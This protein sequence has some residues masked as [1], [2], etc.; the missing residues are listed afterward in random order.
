MKIE[1]LWITLRKRPSYM[2]GAVILLGFAVMAIVGPMLYPHGIPSNPNELYAPPSWQHPLG[3][4]YAGR[5][6]LA[7][8]LVGSR[9]VLEVAALAA[10]FTMVVGVVLGL[11]SGYLG[12]V[13]DVVL[14]R[15]T[16]FILTVPSYPLLIIIASVVSISGPV[17]MALLLTLNSWGGMARAIRSQV[18][19]LKQ[20]DYIEAARSLE[21]GPAHIAFREILPMMMPY[22]LMHLIL[23]VTSAV[24]GEVGL[25]FLGI[26]PIQSTNWGVM[27][28][29]AYSEA[30]AIY[31]TSS[32]FYLMAPLAAII[33]L[34]MGAVN[35]TNA[36]DEVFNPQ[37]R[38]G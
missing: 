33:L 18:L 20:Q 37:L 17:P 38:E 31:S 29:F 27:L 9:Y 23:A 22:I 28:N 1:T 11:L 34:Q 10:L 35:F 7:Q 30:G 3:T 24:Y 16:D 4:D 25:F 26:V 14:M 21:L 15:L 12:G 32:V 36:L 13:V 2:L 6:V 5:G 19:S 8:I